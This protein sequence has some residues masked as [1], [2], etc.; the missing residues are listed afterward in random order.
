MKLRIALAAA[1][2]SATSGI[3][4]AETLLLNCNLTRV[5]NADTLAWF[6]KPPTDAN[7]RVRVLTMTGVIG[8]ALRP[9]NTWEITLPSG[10][11]RAPSD[12]TPFWS[13]SI[14]RPASIFG[15]VIS[16]S[17]SR[18]YFRF[19]RISNTVTVDR[20]P[21][22]NTRKEWQAKHGAPLPP[23]ISFEQQCTVKTA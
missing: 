3:A 19:N 5:E 7:E 2:L 13:T 18:M 8:F 20:W 17:G 22:Q 11:I 21:D 10:A 15:E 23:Y 16:P 12:D 9:S 4:S 14:V 1:A 6:A